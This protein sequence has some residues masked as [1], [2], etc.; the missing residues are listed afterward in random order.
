MANKNIQMENTVVNEEELRAKIEAEVRAKIEEE[1][2]TEETKTSE[3]EKSMEKIIEKQEK[4]LRQ[5]LESFPKVPIVIPEDESNPDDVVPVGWNGIIYAIP[6]GKQFMVP[7]P[8]YDIW[9]ESHTKTQAVNKRI[10]ESVT[11]EIKVIE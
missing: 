11:K 2:K 7:K 10:R 8:I 1:R 4:T 3:K 9:K 5:Q 6:R